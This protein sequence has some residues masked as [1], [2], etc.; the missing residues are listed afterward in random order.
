MGFLDSIK[1]MFGGGVA[2]KFVDKLVAMCEQ[3][4]VNREQARRGLGT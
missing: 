1:G 2:G 4:I 3:E